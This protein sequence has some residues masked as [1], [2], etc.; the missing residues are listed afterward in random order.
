HTDYGQLF[1][2]H[3]FWDQLVNKLAYLALANI[4]GEVGGRPR[5]PPAPLADTSL[6]RPSSPYVYE[7][8]TLVVPPFV[9]ATADEACK[10]AEYE[11]DIAIVAMEPNFIVNVDLA[12]T[13]YTIP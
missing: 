4:L 2:L 13:V 6:P 11:E 1:K 3:H 10:L 9:P 12:N 7:Q 5:P 8:M